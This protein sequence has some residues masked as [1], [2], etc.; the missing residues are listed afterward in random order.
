MFDSSTQLKSETNLMMKL[1]RKNNETTTINKRIR[2]NSCGSTDSNYSSTSSLIESSSSNNLIIESQ[3]PLLLKQKLFKESSTSIDQDLLGPCK[4]GSPIQLEG[5][6]WSETNQGVLVLNVTWKGKTFIGALMDTTNQSWA[7]PMFNNNKL[8]INNDNK[9]LLDDDEQYL[10]NQDP[11][12]RTLRN[13]KR[14][15]LNLA[16][17]V[18][19]N[20][21]SNKKY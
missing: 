7:P 17:N 16:N 11:S 3:E 8:I 19:N 15:H 1:K 18:V 20:K 9:S 5:I 12:I 2:R 21:K 4:S 13:G 14:R 6:V 10:L